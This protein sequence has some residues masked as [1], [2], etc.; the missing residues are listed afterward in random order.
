[1]AAWDILVEGRE[2]SWVSLGLLAVMSAAAGMEHSLALQ[3]ENG[4]KA[5]RVV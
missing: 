5:V 3:L 4:A 1:M 2:E